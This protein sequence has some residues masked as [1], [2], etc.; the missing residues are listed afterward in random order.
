MQIL[1]DGQFEDGF[2]DYNREPHDCLIDVAVWKNLELLDGLY[3][4]RQVSPWIVWNYVW[5]IGPRQTLRKVLSRNQERHRNEKYV[6]CGIGFIRAIPEASAVPLGQAVVFLAPCHPQLAQ[7]IVLPTQLL[8]PVDSSNLPFLQERQIL[9]E[10]D[11]ADVSEEKRW[12]RLI[13]GWNPQSGIEYSPSIWGQLLDQALDTLS[14]S[15]WKKA[16][17]WSHP[18]R[19]EVV[20]RVTTSRHP[21]VGKRS[22]V[23][24]GYGHYAKNI[25]IPNVQRYLDVR[26]IHEID[27][28]RIPLRRRK[29]VGWDTAA[30]VRED[31]NY[32]VFLITGFHHTHA[33]L[34]INALERNVCA[35]VEKPIAVDKH[36]LTILVDAMNRSRGK[37]FCCFHKRYSDFNRL[38]RK[39]LNLLPGQPVSYHCIVYEVPM[40][41][42]HWYKWP[43]SKSRLITNGCHWIDHLQRG[44]YLRLDRF[45]RSRHLKLLRHTGERRLFYYGD[46]L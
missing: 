23:L 25:I 7:R 36:Q 33:P 4:V 31:E 27:P 13:R 29:S 11:P 21:N 10:I 16:A 38:A 1:V 22:A 5:D 41:P 6:A 35:L 3:V 40:P 17:F 9:C 19:A 37:I 18:P 26:A 32:G 14:R 2:L 45:S 30:K 8:K 42:L 24:F 12:W 44:A 28:L 34:A 39:D 15:D 46:D 20:T 43:N